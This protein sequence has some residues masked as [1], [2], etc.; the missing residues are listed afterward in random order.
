[1]KYVM[2]FIEGVA[3]GMVIVGVPMNLHLLSEIADYLQI[4]AV[5][6]GE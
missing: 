6:F 5:A 3:L 4:I 2:E 1:M